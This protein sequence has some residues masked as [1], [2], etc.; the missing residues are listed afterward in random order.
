MIK[1]VR[2]TH[3]GPLSKISS[4]AIK[5]VAMKM[6]ID[7][8]NYWKDEFNQEDN[9]RKA[10][11]QLR[12]DIKK[13]FLPDIFFAEVNL[14]RI[15]SQQ[16][17]KL[18]RLSMEQILQKFLKKHKF[19]FIPHYICLLCQMQVLDVSQ[20]FAMQHNWTE[21]TAYKIATSPLIEEHKLK[22]ILALVDKVSFDEGIYHTCKKMGKDLLFDC[23]CEFIEHHRRIHY[24]KLNQKLI[25]CPHCFIIFDGKCSLLEHICSCHSKFS[26]SASLALKQRGH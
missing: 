14:L 26:T 17:W 23:D 24:K 7:D 21:L 10:L 13:G 18:V 3:P 20:H 9:F 15:K 4:H 25:L 16:T 11:Q 8:P 2:K 19:I 12:T 6:T 5:S 1:Y 22:S